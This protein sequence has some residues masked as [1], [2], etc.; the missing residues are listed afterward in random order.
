MPHFSDKRYFPEY[1]SELRGKSSPGIYQYN[2]TLESSFSKT[3]PSFNKKHMSTIPTE[4]RTCLLWPRENSK[5]VRPE[6]GQYQF[7]T[8]TL[9]KSSHNHKVWSSQ[10]KRPDTLKHR[11][12]PIRALTLRVCSDSDKIRLKEALLNNYFTKKF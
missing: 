11:K 1:K 3:R 9:L 4:E 10:E 7:Q 12:S 8:S 2:F 6:I 5:E